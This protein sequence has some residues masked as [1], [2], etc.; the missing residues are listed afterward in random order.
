MQPCAEKFRKILCEGKKGEVARL[1]R[2]SHTCL[3]SAHMKRQFLRKTRQPH[4][5]AL[6]DQYERV[7][8]LEY[9]NVKRVLGLRGSLTYE[10]CFVFALGSRNQETKQC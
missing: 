5:R 2:T 4:R 6:P 8:T 7:Q 10:A 9:Q 3:T 1:P